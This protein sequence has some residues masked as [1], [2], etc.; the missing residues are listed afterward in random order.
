MLNLI[1]TE[2]HYT[3]LN[4]GRHLF[5]HNLFFSTVY[6]KKIIKSVHLDN[7]LSHKMTRKPQYLDK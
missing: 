5:L 1:E 7:I 2:T 4:M 6:C 3:N